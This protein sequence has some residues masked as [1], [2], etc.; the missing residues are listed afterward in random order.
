MKVLRLLF[1]FFGLM[2]LSQTAYS[3]PQRFVVVGRGLIFALAEPAGWKMDTESGVSDGLPVV[4]YP[5]TQTWD[6]APA[7]MYANTAIKKC[8][9]SPSLVAFINDDV[10]E[11][12][13]HDPSLRVS[14]GGTLS[15]DGRMVT[16]RKFSGD[17]Y[18]NHEVV[19]Y[20]NEKDVF[21][22]FTLS[23]KNLQQYKAAISSFKMLVTSYQ[24]VGSSGGCAK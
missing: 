1:L 23:T 6:T 20:I 5:S 16:L 12:K 7:V 22:S 4:F 10:N 13:S 14:D 3:E 17:R 8:Q 21:V 9:P 19:A 15:A 18:G 24:Y 2:L 11:I